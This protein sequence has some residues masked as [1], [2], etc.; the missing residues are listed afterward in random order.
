[1]GLRTM[2]IVSGGQTGVDRAA[3]DAAIDSGLPHGGW[4]PLGRIAEKEI[5][6]PNYVLQETPTTDSTIRTEWNIRD[7]DATLIFAYGELLH[8]TKLTWE[9]ANVLG[10]PVLMIDLRSTSEDEAVI[11]VSKWLSF[12]QPQTLNVAGSRASENSEI[13]SMVY[14]ALLLVFA[15]VSIRSPNQRDPHEFEVIKSRYEQ[16]LENFRHWDQIRWLVPAWF[17]TIAAA[18]TA[19]SKDLSFPLIVIGNVGLIIFAAICLLLMF[20]L[21]RYH[22]KEV[23]GFTDLIEKSSLSSFERTTLLINL[24]FELRGKKLFLTATIYFV[25]FMILVTALLFI[26]LGW[27]LLHHGK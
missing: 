4:V 11:R 25:I 18:F 6:P 2:K 10:K 21:I 19:L 3:L 8:G 14:S 9:L 17:S 27:T 5:I 7:S 22:N 23:C 12:I 20:N 1:M 15:S 26:S 16:A 13:Y 24:P